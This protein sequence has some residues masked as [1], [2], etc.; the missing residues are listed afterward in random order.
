VH[1]HPRN[2]PDDLILSCARTGGVVCLNGAGIFLGNNDTRIE[3]YFRHMDHVVQLIGPDHVGIGLDYVFDT[4]ELDEYLLKMPDAFPTDQGY[5][6]GL[7]FVSPAQIASL[8]ELQLK[9]GYSKAD[10][11]KILGLNLLRI[12]ECVWKTGS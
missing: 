6:P 2:I 4:R 9:A 11:Q 10:I 12:A 5:V 8:V 1:D 3:T 7:E